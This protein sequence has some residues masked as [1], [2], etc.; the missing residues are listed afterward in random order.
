MWFKNR[1]ARIVLCFTVPLGKRRTRGFI[2]A[3]D[4]AV[5][6]KQ[7]WLQNRC[8]ERKDPKVTWQKHVATFLGPVHTR[9]GA[10]CN[11]CTQIMEHT[12]VNGS[13]HTSCKQHQRVCTQICLYVLCERGLRQHGLVEY[14]RVVMSL[15]FWMCHNF[16]MANWCM[17]FH[18]PMSQRSCLW[19]GLFH[20]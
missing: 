7:V 11:R 20:L 4:G 13:V 8:T 12:A 1:T 9:R 18:H 16:G 10:P 5:G 14:N 2:A 6:R 17:Y 19:L 3:G 15:L